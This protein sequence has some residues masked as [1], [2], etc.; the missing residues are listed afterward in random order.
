MK[1]K[2]ITA[3]RTA[4]VIANKGHEV[5]PSSIKDCI[6]QDNMLVSITRNSKV[7]K[8]TQV[9]NLRAHPGI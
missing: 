8:R 7:G 2:N 1:I 4:F 6:D 5:V 3:V 9:R